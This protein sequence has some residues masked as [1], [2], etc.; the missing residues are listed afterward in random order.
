MDTKKCKYCA[1]QIPIDAKV[2]PYCRKTQGWTVPAKIFAIFVTLFLFG[3]FFGGNESSKTRTNS[4]SPPEATVSCDKDAARNAQDMLKKMA[5][6][7]V[8]N[9]VVSVTWG[10]DWDY[11]TREQKKRLIETFSNA[12]ACLIG[13]SR[14][15]MFFRSGVN[16]GEADPLD[17]IRLID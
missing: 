15:I 9:G 4:T 11:A 5:T 6:W 16:V 14:L 1:M 7:K 13:G 2:C 12:D 8:R 3:L 17:G 10:K